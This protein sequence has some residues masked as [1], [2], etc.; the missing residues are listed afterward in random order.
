VVKYLRN[1][2]VLLIP[3]ITF[4]LACEIEGKPL[5]A[6]INF[7]TCTGLKRGNYTLKVNKGDY[8][9]KF[10]YMDPLN[11]DKL[12][13][14]VF[15]NWDGYVEITLETPQSETYIWIRKYK[16]PFEG[17]SKIEFKPSEVSKKRPKTQI[18]EEYFLIRKTLREITPTRFYEK[19]AIYPLKFYKR[20]SSPFGV[21]RYIN[22][23][24]TG[25]HKGVDFAA[26]EGTPVYAVLSGKV[27][28]ARNLT[29]PGNT[30]VID[31]GWG[32]MTLYAHLS[33]IEVKE[34]QFV[35]QGMEIGKVGS[36]GRSTGPHLH[37]GVYIH[38]IAVEPLDFLSRELR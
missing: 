35:K 29:L 8:I 4:A 5:T 36:T 15:R 26:P 22:G 33:K 31:H 13:F 38:D 32:L 37:F 2:L 6:H 14:A 28:L 17:V 34:G 9:W 11:V 12:P 10:K 27:V 24:Y 19:K 1:I 18:R 23:R 3:L 16:F 7:L 20:I 25:F 30:I 21:R